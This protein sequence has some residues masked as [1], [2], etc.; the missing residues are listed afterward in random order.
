MP[1]EEVFVLMVLKKITDVRSYSL[2]RGVAKAWEGG[3]RW[4]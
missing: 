4:K 3:N 2:C 1:E